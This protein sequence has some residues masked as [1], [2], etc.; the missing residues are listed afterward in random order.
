MKK[1]PL[2]LAHP[3]LSSCLSNNPVI[4][5]EEQRGRLPFPVETLSRHV[6]IEIE[7]ENCGGFAAYDYPGMEH[8]GID[9]DASLRGDS[10][11]EFKTEFPMTC[12]D[13]LKALSSF[14][15]MVSSIRE[16]YPKRFH[17]SERTSIHVH[18]DVRDLTEDEVK[19][20]AKLYMIFEKSLFD[21]AG[22]ARYHNIFCIPL[23]E[24]SLLSDDRQQPKVWWAK[25]DK[26][27]ALNLKT[28]LTFGSVEF[29]AMAGNDN[30]EL[31]SAWVLMLASLVEYCAQTPSEKV[32]EIINT[33]KTESQYQQ[34]ADE[35]FGT[36]YSRTLTMFPNDA[37]A[38]ASLTKLL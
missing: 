30:E 2:F 36:H 25:W 33:L 27:C 29:R 14:F 6:G 7:V 11:Y 16:A 17:F 18:V 20:V 10:A 26:Y 5:K 34:L 31:I 21:F 35:I 15:S 38:A 32:D 22:R 13:S 3:Q 8:W 37:D 9:R 24:S 23:S 28:V 4:V 19:S 12:F 1:R